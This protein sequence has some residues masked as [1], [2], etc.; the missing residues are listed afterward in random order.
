V[1]EEIWDKRLS[2]KV[3]ADFETM[4]TKE[5]ALNHILDEVDEEIYRRGLGRTRGYAVDPVIVKP[6]GKIFRLDELEL[7]RGDCAGR[8]ASET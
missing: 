4:L 5:K 1:G 2:E 8:L 6:G 3:L 7:E